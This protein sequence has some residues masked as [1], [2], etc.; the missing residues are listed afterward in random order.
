M[1]L[2]QIIF[3]INLYL[4]PAECKML[5]ILLVLLK[6]SWHF[7]KNQLSQQLFKNLM[8]NINIDWTMQN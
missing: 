2:L 5:K 6:E 3:S 8:L 4:K 7:S 1:S